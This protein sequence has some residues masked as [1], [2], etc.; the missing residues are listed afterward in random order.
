MGTAL[1]TVDAEV[2][3]VDCGSEKDAVEAEGVLDFVGVPAAELIRRGWMKATGA[4]DSGEASDVAE[5]GEVATFEA[6]GAGEGDGDV[7]DVG[8]FAVGGGGAAGLE[9]VRCT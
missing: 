2:V 6:L 9:V 7:G 5:E 1:G 8:D 4:E 3:V